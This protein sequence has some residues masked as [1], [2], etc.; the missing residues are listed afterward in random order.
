MVPVQQRLSFFAVTGGGAGTFH[1]QTVSETDSLK[2][3]SRSL[4]HGVFMFGGGTDLR[5]SRWVSLRGEIRDLVTGRELSGATGR[6]HVLP[7]FG[8]AFHF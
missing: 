7:L 2:I 3:A 4:I 1:A 6:H 8:V 5:L